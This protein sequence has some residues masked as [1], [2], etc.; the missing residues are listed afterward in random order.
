VE[1]HNVFPEYADNISD[2]KGILSKAKVELT[3]NRFLFYF[4]HL[5][6]GN[7]LALYPVISTRLAQPTLVDI[8]R[9]SIMVL[10][11]KSSKSDLQQE[12]Q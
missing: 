2:A 10:P 1:C 11:T 8:I 3:L 7:V 4:I 9:I 12:K 5:T 6:V